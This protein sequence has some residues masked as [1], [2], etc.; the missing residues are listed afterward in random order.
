MGDGFSDWA[1]HVWWDA[2]PWWKKLRTPKPVCG[3]A[4]VIVE[5]RAELISGYGGYH[6][7]EVTAAK[8][9][10]ACG[11]TLAVS[12]DHTSDWLRYVD[13]QDFQRRAKLR[14]EHFKN[15]AP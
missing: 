7:I 5:R 13:A 9:C 12:P 15:D 11:M 4:D 8:F 14:R 3:H 1:V 6:K 10:P 2:L